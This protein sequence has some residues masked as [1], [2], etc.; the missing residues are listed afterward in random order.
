VIGQDI[1]RNDEEVPYL[2]AVIS[3]L[4]MTFVRA[5]VKQHGRAPHRVVD[6]LRTLEASEQGLGR[7]SLD[8]V[9]EAAADL[10]TNA[11]LDPLVKVPESKACAVRL[12]A[13]HGRGGE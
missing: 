10:L 8:V 3:V 5:A 13:L 7:P 12:E 6:V 11:A 2:D 9:A 4:G 1:I